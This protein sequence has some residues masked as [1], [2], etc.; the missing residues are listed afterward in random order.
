MITYSR[1]HEQVIACF[2]RKINV[3][4][5]QI[6]I[7]DQIEIEAFCCH[8]WHRTYTFSFK[9]AF[10]GITSNKSVFTIRMC[11]FVYLLPKK[12]PK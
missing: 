6:N 1:N 5:D 12:L 4:N 3:H 7:K 9:Y 2:T 8:Q 11:G 10:S